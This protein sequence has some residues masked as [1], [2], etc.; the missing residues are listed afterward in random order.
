LLLFLF[1]AADVATNGTLLILNKPIY[2]LLSSIRG[3]YLDRIM[4]A[5]TFLGEE[6]VLLG[7]SSL[8]FCWLLYKRYW[9]AALHFGLL[10]VFCASSVLEIKHLLF[11]KRPG[12]LANFLQGSSFPSGHTTLSLV[13]Y[14]FGAVIVARE[15]RPNYNWLPYVVSSIV[16]TLIAFS[17]LY[18][19]AHWLTDVIGGTMLGLLFLLLFTISYRRRY[20]LLKHFSPYE[21]MGAALGSL[22]AFWFIFCTIDLSNNVRGYA[23]KWPNTGITAQNWQQEIGNNIPLYR[24]NRIGL[25]TQ[26][27]NVEWIGDLDEIEQSL[28]VRGWTKQPTTLDLHEISLRLT[29]DNVAT[30]LPLLPQLYHDQPIALL[31]TKKSEGDDTIIILRLWKSGIDV[32][33]SKYTLWLGAVD[34][35]KHTGKKILGILP[36]RDKHMPR[37]ASAV[38]EL[39]NN[40]PGFKYKKIIYPEA[41]LPKEMHDLDWDREIL[42][43]RPLLWKK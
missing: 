24:D 15:L 21:F 16:V 11:Y 7:A 34:Y 8:L 5:I 6:K 2:H 17:R 4:V 25:A 43:V 3:N 22:L 38:S 37:F 26:A 31:M 20:T 9:Y 40:L 23:L 42:M 14:G 10:A 27:F 1:V 35:N 32:K 30:Y 13:I 33:A 28:M 19:G 36:K 41:K 39:G 18:L 29:G 12:D